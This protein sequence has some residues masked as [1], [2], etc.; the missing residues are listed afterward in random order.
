[1][2]SAQKEAAKKHVIKREITIK[3]KA[4]VDKMVMMSDDEDEFDACDT[5]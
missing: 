5:K 3:K 1:M 4:Q 2:P